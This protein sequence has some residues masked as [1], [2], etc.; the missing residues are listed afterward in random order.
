MPV[1]CTKQVV[2]IFSSLRSQVRRN[3]SPG[4]R[5]LSGD[6]GTWPRTGDGL[7]KFGATGH[8]GRPKCC[9]P[10]KWAEG[11]KLATSIDRL[12]VICYAQINI[13]TTLQAVD[14][15]RARTDLDRGLTTAL[16]E[17]FQAGAARAYTNQGCMEI[18]ELNLLLAK[19]I[20]NTGV[21]YCEAR[22]LD[23]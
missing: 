1:C 7:F 19:E 23:T 21:A 16:S 14:L 2:A 12:C 8:A 3:L 20:L 5:H 15:D 13:G 6:R 18:Y 11:D 17:V 4:G 22:D 9:P 10:L